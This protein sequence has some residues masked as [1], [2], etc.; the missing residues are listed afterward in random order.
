MNHML[1]ESHD[2]WPAAG[3][4]LSYALKERICAACKENVL[5]GVVNGTVKEIDLSGE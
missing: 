5:R 4:N 1:T 3:S 2:A